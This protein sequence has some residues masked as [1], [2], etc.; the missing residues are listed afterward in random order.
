MD[1][2]ANERRSS[3]VIRNAIHLMRVAIGEARERYMCATSG[4][5][6]KGGSP[7]QVVNRLRQVDL[8]VPEVL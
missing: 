7:E 4:G 8:I 2:L 1:I 3:P 5:S 6:L